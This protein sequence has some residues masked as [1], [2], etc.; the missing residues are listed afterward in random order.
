MD[1]LVVRAAAAEL[2]R[3]GAM[4]LRFNFRGVGASAGSHDEG[5]GEAKDLAAAEAKLT[6]V[7]GELP[8]WLVGYSFGAVMVVRRIANGDS[9]LEAA[10]LLAP[11]IAHRRRSVSCVADHDPCRGARPCGP[12]SRNDDGR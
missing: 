3:L 6:E 8:L 11:P 1:N 10:T 2:R 9:R 12:R 4:T 7:A 5:R